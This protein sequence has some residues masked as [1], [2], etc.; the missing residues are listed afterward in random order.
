[1]SMM[2]EIH[3]AMAESGELAQY[4]SDAAELAHIT[5]EL[6]RSERLEIIAYA[7]RR[8]LNDRRF[9]LRLRMEAKL[10]GYAAN[11]A[12]SAVAS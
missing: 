5:A 11:V 12:R 4:E 10:D 2:S 3:A 1:M 6:D 7:V 8:E 9:V